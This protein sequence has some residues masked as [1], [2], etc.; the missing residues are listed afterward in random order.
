MDE[1]VVGKIGAINQLTRDEAPCAP[2]LLKE[3]Q[4]FV[5]DDYE[6][7]PY[8]EQVI[9]N[10]SPKERAFFDK[11]DVSP[12]QV[13]KHRKYN[14]DEIARSNKCC[15]YYCEKTFDAYEIKEWVE[16]DARQTAICPYCGKPFVLGD[17]SNLPIYD[18]DFIDDMSNDWL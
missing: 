7:K 13:M 2:E 10:M 14:R 3:I 11:W 8:E 5:D 17:A 16:A 12:F 9:D 6:V 15:C 18:F 1:L 4:G